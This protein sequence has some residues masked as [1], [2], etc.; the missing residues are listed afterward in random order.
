MILGYFIVRDLLVGPSAV[1]S[2]CNIAD[3][4]IKW[5]DSVREVEE[6]EECARESGQGCSDSTN[7]YQIGRINCGKTSLL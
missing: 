6:F 5:K 4:R 7:G 3:G 1:P 2:N